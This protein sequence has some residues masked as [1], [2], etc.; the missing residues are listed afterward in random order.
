ML[1]GFER[2][3]K[4]T[5]KN[6]ADRSFIRFGRKCDTDL[7]VNIRNGQLAV[8]GCELY[9]IVLRGFRLIGLDLGVQGRSCR[10][11]PAIRGRNRSRDPGPGKDVHRARERQ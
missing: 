4:P 9:P 10:S 8:P 7:S 3:T 2:S 5:F 6:P 1:E 11:F